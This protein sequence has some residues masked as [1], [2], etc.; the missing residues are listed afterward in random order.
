MKTEFLS[1][2]SF[3]RELRGSQKAER[4]IA[5]MLVLWVLTLLSIMV[6]EF[7][8]TMRIEA[9]ITKNFKEGERSYFIAQAGINR[10][11]IEIVKTKSA[12]KK[13]KGSKESMVKDEEKYVDE[14]EEGSEEWK[15][16]EEPYTFPFQGGECEVKIG[17]EGS[18]I[19]LNWIAKKAKSNRKLLTDILENSC[20][21]EGEERDVIVDSIIDWVDKDHNHLI[22]GAE[23]EYYESLEDPYE[24]RDGNFVVTEELLLVR[25]VTEEIYYGRN[26]SSRERDEL[27][28]EEGASPIKELEQGLEE[29]E[30]RSIGEGLSELFTVF[31]NRNSLKININDAPYGLLMSVSGMTDDVA[32]RIIELRREEE[33]ENISDARLMEL[34]NY[35]QITP[36]ITVDSTDY[37]KIE[38]RGRIDD[39]SVARTI[40]AVVK[41]TPK[42]KDK[43]KVVYWQ[44]GV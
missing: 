10:A 28:E 32:R 4:G 12:V 7:C 31:S 21:L 43:Y 22:N 6:F 25:G 3:L 15:P 29:D 5:L 36:Q 9:T 13:F 14:E 17:D 11:I 39:S 23:D 41:I 33:F 24:S 27:I 35:N 44:E 38:A 18:K 42:K 37:Y 34:P 2:L 8:Y 19:N 16:R 30:E 40:S 26:L 1:F 20:G